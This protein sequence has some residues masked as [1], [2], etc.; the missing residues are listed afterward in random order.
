MNE[1]KQ[2]PFCGGKA[3]H[4]DDENIY[5][6]HCGVTF[7]LDDFIYRGEAEDYEEAREMAIESWNR[8]A[9]EKLGKWTEIADSVFECS[10]CECCDY[11]ASKYCP[12]CGA[13]MED[14]D[15]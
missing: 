10:E 6:Y 12:N 4:L 13:K 3:V 1:L 9:D 8:R 11:E 14:E 7:L 5:C 2:C 15:G